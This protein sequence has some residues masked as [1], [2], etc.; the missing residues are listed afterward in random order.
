M[1]H[2]AEASEA[3]GRVLFL[4]DTAAGDADRA[5]AAAARFAA[6]FNAEIEAVSLNSDV[7]GRAR[8]LPVTCAT[9]MLGARSAGEVLERAEVHHEILVARQFKAVSEAA[10]RAGVPHFHTAV[11]GEA[12]DQLDGLC[13]TR[14]PWNVIVLSAPAK[15]QTAE[16]VSSIFANVSGATGIVAV[17]SRCPHPDGAIAIVVED[18]ERLPAMLRAAGRL[19]GLCGRVH[20]I[21]AA[22]RRR[23]MEDLD[24]HVRLIT[25]NHKG[26]V[27]EPPS[28]LLGVPGALDETL[29]ALKPSFIIARFGGALLPTPQSMAR[30]MAVASA[31]FLLVR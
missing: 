29:R 30:T 14:G 12:V 23:E 18:A 3:N 2:V 8:L 24:A 25:A 7:L 26:L 10:R 27:I 21:V 16:M 11:T 1:A 28:A 20:L 4:M 15:E 5:A 22:D 13:L 9:A 31:P 6:S 19:K 17:P